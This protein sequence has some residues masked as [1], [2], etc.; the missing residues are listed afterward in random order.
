M[1]KKLCTVGRDASEQTIVLH[2]RINRYAGLTGFSVCERWGPIG[3]DRVMSRYFQFD[4]PA[5]GVTASVM[6]AAHHV[7]CFIEPCKSIMIVW[8]HCPGVW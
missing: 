8:Q 3:V 1:I 4:L 6:A 2:L 5:R 7:Y